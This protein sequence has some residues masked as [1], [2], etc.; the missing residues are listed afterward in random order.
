[1]SEAY[2]RLIPTDPTYVPSTE[3]AKEALATLASFWPDVEL[4]VLN[5]DEIQFIDQ[6]SNF[7]SIR[8]P[9]CGARL[10]LTWWSQAMSRAAAL[11]FEDL[12]VVTPCCS[13]QTSLNDLIYYWPAGFAKFAISVRNPN[14]D[15]E[16]YETTRLAGMLGTSL[17][18]VWAH[19]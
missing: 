3:E 16:P 2:L 5:W 7:E 10:D 11:R 4:T 9:Q 15:L 17:R 13:R 8:C 19:Y 6:G 1:M 12:S 18:I 14:K